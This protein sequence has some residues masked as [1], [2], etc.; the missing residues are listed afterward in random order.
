ML[1]SR[2]DGRKTKG[3]GRR[4]RKAAAATELALILPA[5][6]YIAAITIDYSRLFFAWTTIAGC[7]Y[8]GAS[9]ASLNPGAAQSAVSVAALT[10]ATDLTNPAPTVSPITSGTDSGG[11][12]YVEVTVSYTFQAKFTWPGMPTTVAL[13]RKLRMATTP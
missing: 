6:C 5:L 8:N 4:R 7:A 10:D 3:N 12:L 11:N 1:I 13:S 9:Y 2:L